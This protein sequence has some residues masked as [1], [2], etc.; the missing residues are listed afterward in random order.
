[1]GAYYGLPEARFRVI[2]NYEYRKLKDGTRADDKVYA[3][4]QIRF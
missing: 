4:T 3:W 2:V 1:M